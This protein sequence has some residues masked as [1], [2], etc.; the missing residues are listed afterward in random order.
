[1]RPSQS[2]GLPSL[3]GRSHSPTLRR[4]EP[5]NEVTEVP[6]RRRGACA[7]ANLRCG[8]RARDLV[9]FHFTVKQNG[10][11]SFYGKILHFTW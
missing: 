4:L 3:P 2:P 8:V 7:C 5:L 10:T 6:P 11:D 9:I 1:M